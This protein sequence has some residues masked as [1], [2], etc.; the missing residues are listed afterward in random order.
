VKHLSEQ[1]YGI[2]TQCF[3]ADTLRTMPRGYVDTFLQKVNGKIGGLNVTIDMS[4]LAKLPFDSK[5]TMMVGIDLTHP[6]ETERVSAT[7]TATVGSYDSVPLVKL[8]SPP[9]AGE[10]TQNSAFPTATGRKH[11]RKWALLPSI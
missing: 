1:K 7:I 4:E 8:D 5:R 6:G 10:P 9:T 2:M 11:S 3:K